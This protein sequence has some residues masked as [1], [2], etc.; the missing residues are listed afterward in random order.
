[1]NFPL[2][3]ILTI[4]AQ[5][6]AGP[7]NAVRDLYELAGVHC[8]GISPLSYIDDFAKNIPA[9]TEVVV[10]YRI[11][12]VGKGDYPR[13]FQSGTALIPKRDATKLKEKFY[14]PPM[15]LPE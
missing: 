14:C 9:G 1:M 7:N 12:G 5:E 8:E 6:Y 4:S 11:L 15:P 2:E 10:G 3:K 13:T